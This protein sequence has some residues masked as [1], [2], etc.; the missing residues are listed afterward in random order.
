MVGIFPLQ[1]LLLEHT[2]SVYRG[3]EQLVYTLYNVP[4]CMTRVLPVCLQLT[5]V[6]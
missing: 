1:A 4:G 3:R 5:I 6:T 2:R